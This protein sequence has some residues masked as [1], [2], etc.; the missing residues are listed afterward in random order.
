MNEHVFAD[1]PEDYTSTAPQEPSVEERLGEFA[2]MLQAGRA[3]QWAEGDILTEAKRT[4]GRKVLGQFAEIGRCSVRWCQ[5]RA[6]VAETFGRDVRATYP[7]LNWSVFEI[8]ARTDDPVVWLQ[9]AAD[10][11]WSEAQLRQAIRGV[12]PET[13]KVARLL[14]RAE[15]ILQAG[16]DD[17]DALEDGM[18]NLLRLRD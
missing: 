10:N 6:K 11:G 14:K 1:D 16:G 2:E 3:T 8:A 4:Y 18:R 13:P 17:A 12:K 5:R 9:R 7:D 15:E